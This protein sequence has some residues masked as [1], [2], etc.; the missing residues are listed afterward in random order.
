MALTVNHQTKVFTIL[1]AD[2][3]LLQSVPT[4]VYRLNLPALR[5]E[6]KALTDNEI[7]IT[8]DDSHAWFPSQTVSGVQ[9]APVFIMIN[10]FTV[11]FEDGQYAVNFNGANT[12]LGDVTNVNQVSIRPNNSAGLVQVLEIEQIIFNNKIT[13]NQLTGVTGQAYPIGTPLT[14]FASNNFAD[15][16]FIADLRG[17]KELFLVGNNS[18]TTNTLDF[19]SGY[20][21]V[22]DAPLTSVFQLSAAAIVDNCNFFRLTLAGALDSDCSV[23]QCII[24][25]LSFFQGFM[26]YC[27]LT[28]TIVLGGGNNGSFQ[29]CFDH[30][31]DST[32]PI[33]DMGGVGQT[34][35]MTSYEG[36]IKIIN[37]TDSLTTLTNFISG[38]G[39]VEFDSTVTEGVFVVFGAMEVVDNSGPNCTIIDK[40]TYGI[41]TQVR[42]VLLNRKTI[43]PVTGDVTI[44]DD[45]NLDVLFSG[46]AFED[47]GGLQTYRGQGY[48]RVNRLMAP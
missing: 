21:F 18:L 28:S 14:G 35:T 38:I 43:D 37:Y 12:N 46:T 4:F 22:G 31:T 7:G 15:A 42:K 39:K 32:P 20:R 8:Y 36:F 47:I 9:L 30:N 40:T 13:I 2:L 23:D 24:G 33:I 26:N 3:T 6:M 10:G 27:V 34:I 16:K 17:I 48:D 5:V 45:N 1:R 25:N 29:N 19:S 44:L 41:L 11:T